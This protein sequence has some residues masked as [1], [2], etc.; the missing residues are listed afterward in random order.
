MEGCD[1][2]FAIHT[3]LGGLPYDEHYIYRSLTKQLPDDVND[4]IGRIEKNSLVKDGKKYADHKSKKDDKKKT[5]TPLS[6][7]KR[8]EESRGAKPEESNYRAVNTIFKEPIHKIM[9]K[10]KSQP[11]FKWPQPMGSDHTKSKVDLHCSY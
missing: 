7:R 11:Y 4:L 9:N 8:K 6:K 10:I 3:F 5:E 1:L 2:K